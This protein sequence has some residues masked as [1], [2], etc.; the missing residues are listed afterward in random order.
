MLLNRCFEQ[1]TNLT[2]PENNWIRSVY[3][4]ANDKRYAEQ[5]FQNRIF[6][7]TDQQ[8]VEYKQFI[9]NLYLQSQVQQKLQEYISQIP[10]IVQFQHFKTE[11]CNPKYVDLPLKILRQTF[12]SFAFLHMTHLIY[13]LG[14][15]YLLLHQTYSQL[16]KEDEFEMVSLQELINRGQNRLPSANRLQLIDQHEK[17]IKK[18]IKA[19]NDY[20]S[21]SDGLIRPGACDERQRFTPV[22]IETSISY[23]VTTKQHDEGDIIGRIMSILIDYHNDIFN[24]LDKE[25]SSMNET[26]GISLLKD[27]INQFSLRKVSIHQ[28]IKENTGV[29]SISTDDRK[30]IEC[31][32]RS[33]L[34]NTNEYFLRP[35]SPLNFN[36]LYIQ[37]YLIRSYFLFCPISYEHLRE[38]YR[39]YTETRPN[40]IQEEDE[41]RTEYKVTDPQFEYLQNISLEKLYQGYKFLE[42]FIDTLQTDVE[43][44]TFFEFLRQTCQSDEFFK[45]IESY[46][47]K[48]FQFS[49][50]K[51]IYEIY[52]ELI[53]NFNYSILNSSRLLSVPLSFELN[54]LLDEILYQS[55][56]SQTPEQLQSSIR[57]ISEFLDDLKDCVPGFTERLS[58]SLINIYIDYSLNADTIFKIIPEEVKCE[59]YIPVIIKLIEIRSTFQEKIM[60]NEEVIENVWEPIPTNQKAEPNNGFIF[61]I[62]QDQIKPIPPP[63]LR[64]LEP[65]YTFLFEFNL[66]LIPLPSSFLT[67]KFNNDQFTEQWTFKINYLDEM[68][69]EYSCQIEEIQQRLKTIFQ[70]KN[71]DFDQFAL[72]DTNHILI[73]LNI[74]N[75]MKS[76]LSEEYFIITKDSLNPIQIEFEDKQSSYHITQTT[77]ISSLIQRFLFDHDKTIDSTKCHLA[78]FDQFGMFIQDDQSANEHSFLKLVQYDIDSTKLLKITVKPSDEL[79][80]SSANNSLAKSFE[81]TTTTWK[82]ISAWIEKANLLET[83]SVA[84]LEF[85]NSEVGQTI[86]NDETV[87]S[88][89]Y[90][91]TSV[92]INGFIRE[93]LV[94][95]RISYN[96]EQKII[97]AFAS[98]PVKR[99]LPINNCVLSLVRENQ[100][101]QIAEKDFEKSIREFSENDEETLHFRIS[102]AIKIIDY[103]TREETQL[104]VSNKNLTIKQLLELLEFDDN[105]VRYLVSEKMNMI[106]SNDD[107]LANQTTMNFFAIKQEH[108]RE[109]SIEGNLQKFMKNSLL[110]HVYQ[111][112][113]QIIQD[114]YLVYKKHFIFPSNTS[115]EQFQ[116]PIEFTQTDQQFPINIIVSNEINNTSCQFHC[117]SSI[118]IRDVK[119]LATEF[120]QANDNQQFFYENMFNLSEEIVIDRLRSASPLRFYFTEEKNTITIDVFDKEQNDTFHLQCLPSIL[121]ENLKQIVRSLFNSKLNELAYEE[122]FI[123]SQDIFN[124]LVQQKSSFRFVLVKETCLP[125]I[126]VTNDQNKSIN[127]RCLPSISS[128]NLQDFTCQQL[129]VVN[130]ENMNLVYNDQFALSRDTFNMVLNKLSSIRFSLTH[131]TLPLDITITN[132]EDMSINFQCS[133][134]ISLENVKEFACQL[135]NID[136]DNANLVYQNRFVLS[137]D[138]FNILGTESDSIELMI[139]TQNYPSNITIVNDANISIQFHC[140]SSL[141][142]DDLRQFACRMFHCIASDYRLK[143]SDELIQQ[144][145]VSLADFTQV[146]DDIQFELVEGSSSI[147]LFQLSIQSERLTETN[148]F[149]KVRSMTQ[150]SVTTPKIVKF[151]IVHPNGA[152]QNAAMGP[153]NVYTRLNDAFKE[154]KYSGD[155]YTIVDHEKVFVDSSIQI[156]DPSTTRF[157]NEYSI[158]QK[159]DLISVIVQ[160]ESYELEYLVTSECQISTI[161]SRFLTNKSLVST[162]NTAFFGFFDQLGSYIVE[163]QSISQIY[164]ANQS[165]SIRIRVR[166]YKGKTENL[167]EVSLTA[168]QSKSIEIL[169]S[170]F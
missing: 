27:L 143:F 162:S 157:S 2:K 30:T 81:R 160:F 113:E 35:D 83:I 140:K 105:Q 42:D 21:F 59:N 150:T 66:E 169:I 52:R 145:E 23:L 161:L 84:Q 167:Y 44:L 94:D 12:D 118:T 147:S 72:V 112:N 139:N 75:P 158:I 48:D 11:L 109:V 29:I 126:T 168:N 130:E 39:C 103:D 38:P 16:V 54:Q 170:L 6:Y 155:Q 53:N 141:S 47:I 127:F 106:L 96:N 85:W 152:R 89:A 163:D 50:I 90:D 124:Y 62:K 153:K 137:Q 71:Y 142:L 4:N 138:T 51:A 125:N 136:A 28:I 131:Q 100:T 34:D 13:D 1:L 31:L 20:H 144:Y 148:L 79:P 121:I 69:E 129:N 95:V 24:L 68:I 120:V 107:K 116:S 40:L 101:L 25:I 132:D 55:I 117:Q 73:D 41:Q 18:G 33:S 3:K 97:R 7:P 80:L 70:E 102:V 110:K 5:E 8:I 49:K 67:D 17:I 111:Q 154:K 74:E 19:I 65:P 93:A 151:E 156:T 32:A 57:S 114:Q 86:E 87:S 165:D 88:S 135:L 63:S 128:E 149:K 108:V 104:T 119:H 10:L 91:F 43:H 22:S 92:M 99:I 166:E 164:R 64:T 82:Q 26:H 37:Y 133:Q 123:L 60:R 14:Q 159:A 146:H 76:C 46:G 78:V 122:D 61:I 115:L 77:P 58:H 15:F 56:P 134:S 98:T 9:T 36:F 45:K